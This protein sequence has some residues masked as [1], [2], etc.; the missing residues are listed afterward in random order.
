MEILSCFTPKHG[1]LTLSELA[2]LT[3]LPVSTCH[4]ITTTLVDG[5][6]LSRGSDR[7][8]RVGTK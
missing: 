5:G 3:K 7:K 4:R 8:F 2:E 6:F 1:A